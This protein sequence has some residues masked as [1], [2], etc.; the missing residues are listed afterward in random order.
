LPLII[1]IGANGIAAMHP[2]GTIIASA[3][4][5]RRAPLAPVK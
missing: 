4:G 3:C 1:D 5:Q 2:R